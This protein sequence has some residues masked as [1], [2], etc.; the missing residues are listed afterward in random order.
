MSN[1]TRG[2]VTFDLPDPEGGPTKRY[3]LKF[4]NAGRIALESEAGLSQPEI[5][6]ALATGKVGATLL[7]AMLW[8]ATRMHH[9]AQIRNKSMINAIMDQAEET[10]VMEDLSLSLIAAYS[11][12]SKEEIREEIEKVQRGEEIPPDEDSDADAEG[13]EDVPTDGPVD[14][15]PK[16]EG[17]KKKPEGGKSLTEVGRAS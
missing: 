6:F 11:R 1:P 10:E 12:R 7:S 8:G 2:E 13:V 9:S 16:D 4:N 15:G 17:K 5:D 3:K 14:A